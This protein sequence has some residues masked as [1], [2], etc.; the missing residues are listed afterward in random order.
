[1]P[2]N[3]WPADPLTRTIR[4]IPCPD[5]PQRPGLN[6]G[7]P[8]PDHPEICPTCAGY[9]TILHPDEV[10]YT[11]AQFQRMRDVAAYDLKQRMVAKS[12]NADLNPWPEYIEGR[13]SA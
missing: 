9:G 5:C 1:M 12:R 13:W 6:L 11:K 8:N 4:T 3:L 7:S 2:E 10:A